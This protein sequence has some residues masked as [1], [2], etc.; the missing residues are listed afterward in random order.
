MDFQW[1]SQI[2]KQKN[3]YSKGYP[4]AIKLERNVYTVKKGLHIRWANGSARLAIAVMY[5]IYIYQ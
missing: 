2:L 4:D 1:K 3:A 5:I